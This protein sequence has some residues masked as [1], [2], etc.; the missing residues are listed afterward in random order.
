MSSIKRASVERGVIANVYKTRRID[1]VNKKDI[2]FSQ[3][4]RTDSAQSVKR[5]SR[6]FF[7]CHVTAKV[8]ALSVKPKSRR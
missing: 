5:S 6:V 1:H 4:D 7:W 3:K 2:A 8:I